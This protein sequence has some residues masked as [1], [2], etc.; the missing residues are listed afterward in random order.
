MI[1]KLDWD[2]DFFGFNIAHL[3]LD[4]TVNNLSFVDDFV[5]S[6]RIECIQACCDISAID[7]IHLLEENMF[8][9]TDLRATYFVGLD[10]IKI[11]NSDF[12]IADKDDL[13]ILREIARSVAVHSKYYND[14]FG[15]EKAEQ[16]YEIWVEKSVFGNFDNICLK[17]VEGNSTVGFATVKFKGKGEARIGLIGI[18]AP[19]QDR[20]IG[21]QLLNSLFSYLISKDITI[22][23]VSTQGK[24]IRAQNFYSRCGFMIKSLESWYY[25]FYRK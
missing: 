2:S 16:L 22:L 21:R 5:K 9:F 14:R 3:D 12:Y 11:D 19:Y 15:K 7:T 13:L 1:R 4:G 6:N 8:H 17:A 25:K 10:N 23:E 18:R 24:N 20:G